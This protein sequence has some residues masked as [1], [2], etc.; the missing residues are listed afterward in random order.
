MCVCV[1]VCVC[2]LVYGAAVKW[3][4]GMDER[5]WSPVWKEVEQWSMV[6]LGDLYCWVSK[7]QQFNIS[8]CVELNDSGHCTIYYQ[9]TNW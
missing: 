7:K 5:S 4:C 3:R 8:C 1:C 9:F 6:R 2:V